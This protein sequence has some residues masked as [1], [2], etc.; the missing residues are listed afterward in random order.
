MKTKNYWNKLTQEEVIRRATITHNGKYDYSLVVYTK[1]SEKIKII[2]PIH[3]VFE[4]CAG[5]HMKK[6][7]CPKCNHISKGNKN[8]TH[9]ICKT[10][11]IEK[12]VSEFTL[13]KD[14]DTYR[15]SCKTCISKKKNNYYNNNLEHIKNRVKT[16]R[17]HNKEKRNKSH[18][19]RVKND[20]LYKFMFNTRSNIR[21][22][23]KRKNFKKN[24]GTEKILGCS[25]EQFKKH[26]ESKFE[27]WMNWENNGKYSKNKKSWQLDHIIP[28]STAKT[29]DDVIR[30]NH[31]TNFQPLDALENIK[32]GNKF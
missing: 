28:L 16:Y 19:E 11:K 25:I 7:I 8:S 1:E 14:L 20:P 30:L 21:T 29:I 4:Q 2:C 26:I 24:S 3:G 9:L 5:K 15:L 18:K 6:S 22:A 27:S 31:Y 17:K 10:C 32:K 13:R 12:L 23:F